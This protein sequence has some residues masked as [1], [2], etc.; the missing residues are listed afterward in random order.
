MEKAHDHPAQ[1]PL[2]PSSAQWAL[3][4]VGALWLASKLLSYLR[5]VLSAF[6]LSGVNARFASSL[7]PLPDC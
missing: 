6:V 4:V 5:L 7:I 2:V 1:L 3:A